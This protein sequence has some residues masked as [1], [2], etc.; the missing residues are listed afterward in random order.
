MTSF[1]WAV[2]AVFKVRF[3]ILSLVSAAACT[4]LLCNL[5]GCR[6]ELRRRLFWRQLVALAATDLLESLLIF[7]ANVL[8][9][10]ELI[11]SDW[12]S[13]AFYLYL[14]YILEFASCGLEVQIAAG[15]LA[16]CCRSTK[17]IDVLSKTILLTWP[18]AVALLFLALASGTRPRGF[19]NQFDK[20]MC[21]DEPSLVWGVVVLLSCAIACGLYVL[22]IARAL[23][24]ARGMQRRAWLIGL[25][26]LAN[27]L[28]TYVTYGIVSIQ[29]SPAPSSR[30]VGW[31]LMC[32]NGAA[33]ACTYFCHSRHRAWKRS[34]CERHVGFSARVE[35]HDI[36]NDQHE[37]RRVATALICEIQPQ[38]QQARQ[39][40]DI[41]VDH[42]FDV[43]PFWLDYHLSGPPSPARRLPLGGEVPSPL[44]RIGG[45]LLFSG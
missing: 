22:S 26:Y 7:G 37:Q 32:L 31:S 5:L 14:R 16:V 19:N 42:H 34:S 10:H 9:G 2:A 41:I 27:F 36:A 35:T 21:F 44:N 40:L 30:E 45:R 8:W 33:N 13:C 20:G 11:W 38:R 18:C 3:C 39:N 29:R 15:F 12:T 17:S 25:C 43:D 23:R 24:S 4:L 28:G 6:K 1:R